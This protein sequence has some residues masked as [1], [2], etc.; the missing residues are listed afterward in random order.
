MITLDVIGI[1]KTLGILLACGVAAGCPHWLLHSVFRRGKPFALGITPVALAAF[2]ATAVYMDDWLAAAKWLL[3]AAVAFV[4]LVL[5]EALLSSVVNR[6]M[7]KVGDNAGGA[8]RRDR[9]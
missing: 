2:L 9:E 5:F 4:A 8:V 1:L 7:Q 3:C 6:G